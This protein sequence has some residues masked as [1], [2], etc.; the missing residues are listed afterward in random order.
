MIPV[1][2]YGTLKHGFGNHVLLQDSDFID[3]AILENYEMRYSHGNHGFPVIFKNEKTQGHLVIGEVYM[4]D[5]Y[6]LSALDQLESRGT[7]Y[8][9]KK[10]TVELSDGKKVKVHVYIGIPE[11]WN[12]FEGLEPVGRTVHN[13][14]R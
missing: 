9:R 3:D 12:N 2:V 10:V 7:M 4:V 1:F 8:N 5:N 6:T 14:K 11:F 13:F